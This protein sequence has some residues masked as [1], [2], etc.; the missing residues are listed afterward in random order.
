MGLHDIAMGLTTPPRRPGGSK[1]GAEC[2]NLGVVLRQL[3][4][5][6]CQTARAFVPHARSYGHPQRRPHVWVASGET[7]VLQ[8]LGVAEADFSKHL[9][10]VL[11]KISNGYGAAPM[12]TL[13]IP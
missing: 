2:S 4:E 6:L 5:K 8:D 1:G 7:G 12:A 3:E 9:G 10:V 13:R 11:R